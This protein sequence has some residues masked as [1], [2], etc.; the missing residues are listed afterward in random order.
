M[1]QT[2]PTQTRSD[3]LPSLQRFLSVEQYLNTTYRPD[4]DYVDGEIEERNLGEFDH[5]DLQPAIGALLLRQPKGMGCARGGRNPHARL[6][7][8]LPHPRC[9][10]SSPPPSNASAS[11]PIRRCFALKSSPRA[12]P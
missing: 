10:R 5:G 2:Y 9:L 6:A 1:A 7:H 3:E 4:V 8:P 11:S 12:T